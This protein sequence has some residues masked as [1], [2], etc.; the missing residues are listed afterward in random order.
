MN[1]RLIFERRENVL[2]VSRG[3]FVEAHGKRGVYV[4]EHDKA[5]FTEIEIGSLGVR[6][7]ELLRG[8][9]EGDL[10]IIS[11]TS[12]LAGAETVSIFD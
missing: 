6:S 11:D 5:Y 3:P 10:L 7:V 4:M 8:L 2:L 12:K 1:A 9:D